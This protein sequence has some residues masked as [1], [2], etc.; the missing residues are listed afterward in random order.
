MFWANSKMRKIVA[1]YIQLLKNIFRIGHD[2]QRNKW[3]YR[4]PGV[5]VKEN[6]ADGGCAHGDTRFWTAY[7]YRILVYPTPCPKANLPTANLLQGRWFYLA[8]LSAGGL[9]CSIRFCF[10]VRDVGARCGSPCQS[11]CPAACARD[12]WPRYHRG[13]ELVQIQVPAKLKHCAV[14]VC[15]LQHV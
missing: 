4:K 8:G 7:W 3:L 5:P 12:E 14:F 2:S 9:G 10:W 15:C 1:C 13:M 11:Q 6:F